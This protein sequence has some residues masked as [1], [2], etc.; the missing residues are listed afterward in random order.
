MHN[1]IGKLSVFSLILLVGLLLASCAPAAKPAP[2]PA[3]AKPAA[4]MPAPVPAKPAAPAPAPPKKITEVAAPWGPMG[5]TV[6]SQGVGLAKL[7]NDYSDTLRLN[8]MAVAGFTKGIEYWEKSKE[9]Y[10]ALSFS[11]AIMNEYTKG[12]KTYAKQGPRKDQGLVFQ[13]Y[14]LDNF[15][16]SRVGSGIK[17]TADLKG[18]KIAVGEPG[19]GSYLIAMDF[20]KEGLGFKEGD[21]KFVHL[22]IAD[23]V[24]GLKEGTVDAAMWGHIAEKG[25]P[26][27]YIEDV[28]SATRLN[29]IPVGQEIVDRLNKALA[30]PIYVVNTLPAGVYRGQ[31]EAVPWLSCPQFLVMPLAHPDSM[32]YEICRVWWDYHDAGIEANIRVAHSRPEMTK[33]ALKQKW[34]LGWHPGALKWYKERGWI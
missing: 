12:I 21:A 16:V 19:T 8:P 3:P 10:F 32:A 14:V 9:G 13:A 17:T 7:L 4:P 25:I 22:T 2:A 26:Y 30:A 28:S 27:A 31:T 23:I 24:T 15:L 6:Y 18:R 34:D 5:S 33:T 20:F 1:R 29:F 11:T